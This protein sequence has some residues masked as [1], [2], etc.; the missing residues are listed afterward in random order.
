MNCISPVDVRV[1]QAK[2]V[3]FPVRDNVYAAAENIQFV[4]KISHQQ[5]V[6]LGKVNVLLQILTFTTLVIVFV[7]NDI[8]AEFVLNVIAQVEVRVVN[9]H[10]CRFQ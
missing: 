2:S 5:A 6:L 1:I 7:F 9:V 10:I 4:W 3:R 8:V